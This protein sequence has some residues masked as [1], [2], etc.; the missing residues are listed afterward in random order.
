MRDFLTSA[1]LQVLPYLLA[2]AGELD[3]KL[4][5]DL[6]EIRVMLLGWT[7]AK[8]AERSAGVTAVE[9]RLALERLDAETEI[10]GIQ[11]ADFDFFEELVELTDNQV[12]NLLANAV[13]QV[14]MQNSELFGALYLS[15][16]DTELHHQTLRAVEAGDVAAARAA[17]EAY[18]RRFIEEGP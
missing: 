13:R 3:G 4:L 11:E 9:L 16:G 15:P 6:L 7:A 12:L 14:Y 2:P 18:G 17:M 1:G 8:A 5:R 10:R